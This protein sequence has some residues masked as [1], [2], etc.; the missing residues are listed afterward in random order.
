MIRLTAL[1]IAAGI[2]LPPA[3]ALG[4]PV[5]S[6]YTTVDLRTCKRLAA[7]GP[8]T[9]WRCSGLAGM[10]VYVAKGGPKQ[11]VSAGAEAEKQ[12][13]ASQ[14]LGAANSIFAPGSRRATIEWRFERRGAKQLPYAMIVRFH[15]L[16]GERAGDVLVVL[17]ANARE[18]C[19]VAHIAAL[20]NNDAIARARA[21]AD[22]QARTFDCRQEPTAESGGSGPM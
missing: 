10:P 5:K 17:K 15:T 4:N 22:R 6:L 8:R 21:I 19:H 12:R 1:T 11:F 20:A 14:T 7:E 16:G 9:A 18:S 13:A 3:A 2:C